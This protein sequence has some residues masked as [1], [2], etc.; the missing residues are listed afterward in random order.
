MKGRVIGREGRNIRAFEKS[1]GVDVIVDDTPG[2][3]VVSAFDPVRREVARRALER[4]I[5][6]GRIHPGRIEEIV[7]EMTADVN[8]DIMEAGKAAA[9]EANIGGLHKRQIELLGRLAYRTSYGQ[10]VLRH[11]VEVAFLCQ[12][13]AEELGL[14]GRLARRCGLLHDI[15]KALDHEMEGGHPSS[16]T[17]SASDTTKAPRSSTPSSATTATSKRPAPTPRW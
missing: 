2:V 9:V 8:K 11:S 5:Q 14:D 10:N 15:G 13:M 6:D 16:D 7:E 1:T 3:V 4:L 12:N 17:T